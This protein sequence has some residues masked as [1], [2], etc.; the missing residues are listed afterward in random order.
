MFFWVRNK[1]EIYYIDL[2]FFADPHNIIYNM[3]VRR[4][5][6]LY[7]TR[8]QSRAILSLEVTGSTLLQLCRII[9]PRRSD[10]LGGEEP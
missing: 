8:N 10:I 5:L 2:S 6:K 1:S 3:L 7:N 4:S 9:G